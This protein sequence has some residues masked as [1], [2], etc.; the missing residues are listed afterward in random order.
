MRI[1]CEWARG[2]HRDRRQTQLP[3]TQRVTT[4]E[5]T[6]FE[7]LRVQANCANG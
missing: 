2:R 5:P 1:S 6:G 3:V 4:R 7:I